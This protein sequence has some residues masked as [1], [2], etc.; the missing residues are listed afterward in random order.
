MQVYKPKGKWVAKQSELY[1]LGTHL[2]MTKIH[3]LLWRSLFRHAP[4]GA[5]GMR[6][7]RSKAATRK[8]TADEIQ[9][10]LFLRN[11]ASK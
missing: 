8:G 3:K 9:Y 6:D 7:A 10:C 5:H 11:H 2:Y 4:A 1:K